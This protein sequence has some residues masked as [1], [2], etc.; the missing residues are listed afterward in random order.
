MTFNQLQI[1]QLDAN[2]QRYAIALYRKAGGSMEYI[3][4]GSAIDLSNPTLYSKCHKR[5]TNKYTKQIKQ[6]N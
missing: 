2:I 3:F 1:A 5:A 6:G 4:D